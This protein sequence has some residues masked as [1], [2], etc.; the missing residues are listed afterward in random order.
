MRAI[1]CLVIGVFFLCGCASQIGF[2]SYSK[3][4]VEK[5]IHPALGVEALGDPGHLLYDIYGKKLVEFIEIIEPVEGAIPGPL[6]FPF[7]FSF[8]KTTLYRKFEA[9][10]YLYFIAP[11]GDADAYIA[12]DVRAVLN[13]D[14]MGI[15]VSKAGKIEWFVDSS[16]YN[17]SP[18][19]R[20]W[21]REIN[22]DETASLF[23]KTRYERVELNS[24]KTY[25]R[26][27]KR[28][29]KSVT[30]SV[31]LNSVS[32]QFEYSIEKLPM[33][34][35]ISG[36]ILQILAFNEKGQMKYKWV[37]YPNFAEGRLY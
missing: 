8:R 2:R 1:L 11:E 22:S 3:E 30:L 4:P 5:L 12:K 34:V 37:K 36:G 6:R 14:L 13:N 33:E 24:L 19:P 23:H 29:E 20:L 15:R 27:S 25:V 17:D 32:D 28:T 7:K 31:S 9:G 21:T 35:A 10:D 16:A 18:V 26:F